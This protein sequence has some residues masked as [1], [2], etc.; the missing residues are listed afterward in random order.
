MSDSLILCKQL[1]CA[2]LMNA[3]SHVSIISFQEIE[4]I[5]ENYS[6]LKWK[7]LE[8]TPKGHIYYKN[9]TPET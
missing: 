8:N 3:I 2:C 5:T 7:S 4:T 1:V 6:Q 9:P